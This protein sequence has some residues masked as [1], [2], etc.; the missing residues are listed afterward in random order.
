[1]VLKAAPKFTLNP[2]TQ[3]RDSATLYIG[4]CMRDSEMAAPVAAYIIRI[5]YW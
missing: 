2:V 4:F 5:Y 3:F 1:M